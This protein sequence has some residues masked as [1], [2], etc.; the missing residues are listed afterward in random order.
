MLPEFARFYTGCSFNDGELAD[1]SPRFR[2]S[3]HRQFRSIALAKRVAGGA[4]RLAAPRCRRLGSGRMRRLGIGNRTTGS[5]MRRGHRHRGAQPRMPGGRALGGFAIR[6]GSVARC[7]SPCRTRP[8]RH[9]PQQPQPDLRLCHRSSY[10]FLLSLYPAPTTPIATQPMRVAALKRGV[11][12]SS[13]L[14]HRGISTRI[15]S[16]AIG[17]KDSDC[18][19]RWP[20]RVTRITSTN[21]LFIAGPGRWIGADSDW[22]TRMSTPPAAQRRS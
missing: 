10:C 12:Y 15:A 16:W 3:R 18:C 6:P 4:S 7:L 11:A 22:S 14:E 9:F 5:G 13:K 21:A 19:K 17:L 20:K 8:H 2:C 1:E